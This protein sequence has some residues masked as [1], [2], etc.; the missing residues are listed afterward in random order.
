[1]TLFG[2][3]AMIGYPWFAYWVF[4]GDHRAAGYLLGTSIHDTAQVTGAAMMYRQTWSAPEA[5]DVATVTKLLRNSS[6]ALL[7]PLMG[8]LTWR[9][10]AE[11]KKAGAAG[12]FRWSQAIPMFVAGYLVLAGLRSAGDVLMGDR[13]AWTAAL[14][15]ADLTAGW[16]LAVAMA[17]VGLG[18]EL[19]R[20]RRLGWRPMVAGLGAAASV[21]A[22]SLTLLGLGCAR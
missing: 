7:I 21:G 3:L 2:M 12:G 19:S 9:N 8:F 15:Q 4:G 20:L 10:R 13:T 5:L 16:L 18:T 17:A 14:A 11:K 1:V 22:V 6:M